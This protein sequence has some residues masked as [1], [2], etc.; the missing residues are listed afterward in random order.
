MLERQPEFARINLLVVLFSVV[1]ATG[2]YAQESE[3]RG[4][5]IEFPELN[6]GKIT[7]VRSDIATSNLSV[8][9]FWLLS[10]IA[11]SV[12]Y[13][14]IR[15]RINNES[16]NRACSQ[17]PSTEGKVLRCDLNRYFSLRL[18]PKQN[19]LEIEAQSTDKRRFYAA[20]NLVTNPAAAKPSP[21][22]ISP[23]T[24]PLGFS[25]RKFAVILGVSKYKYNDAG[26]GNL[27]F[28]DA[29]ADELYRWLTTKGGF[30]PSD[31]L[32]MTNEAA[33]LNAVR[34]SLEAFLTKATGDRSDSF[35]F[36]RPRNSRP[37]QPKRPLLSGA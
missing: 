32:R 4:L 30:L 10:P 8:I 34:Y 31:V 14:Q 19:I 20:F 2:T 11:D 18:Q 24:S 25:G 35:L 22:N 29:D 21:Q 13:S 15:V 17:A 37:L 6:S 3:R 12:D 5:A 9:K 36:R 1:L 7:A 28:A 23:G 27:A 26:L 16:A 33:T